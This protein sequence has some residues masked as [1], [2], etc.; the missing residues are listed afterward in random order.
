MCE[1][2]T[3]ALWCEEGRIGVG[4]LLWP[5]LHPDLCDGLA[6]RTNE[7]VDVQIWSSQGPSIEI[8]EGPYE[9]VNA[10]TQ[11]GNDDLYIPFHHSR[12]GANECN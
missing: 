6:L 7:N 9:D 11:Y 5:C 10:G 2:V 1:P 12:D 3:N 8:V 4:F